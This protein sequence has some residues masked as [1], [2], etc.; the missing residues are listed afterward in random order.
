MTLAGDR[1][2]GVSRRALMQAAGWSVGLLLAPG[3][4]ADAARDFPTRLVRIVVPYPAGGGVDGLARA[5]AEKLSQ[6]WR[7]P[8]IVENKPGASTMIGSDSVV[9]SPP[10]G[11]T[12]L[13]TSDSTI[14]SNPHLFKKSPY[15]PIKDLAPVTQIID[16]HQMV[17]VHPSVAASTMQELAAL[18]KGNPGTLNYGSY[19]NGSQPHLL[20]EAFRAMTGAQIMHVPYRGIA[21]ALV[22]TIAG[23]VQMTL[24]GAATTGGYFAAGQL[25]PLAVARKE[26]LKAYPLVPTLGEAGFADIDPRPWFGLFAPVGVPPPTIARIQTDVAAILKDPAFREKYIDGMGYTGVGSTPDAFAKFI[27][28]D[29]EY[30]RRLIALA[31]VTME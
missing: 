30:K 22:A 29:F 23:E 20:F 12:L 11:Y 5:V 28:D 19:G 18:A 24:G 4:L 17:V 3:V 27:A 1:P 25:K 21:P 16:L 2:R 10:D 14:T 9:R 31:G 7:Q 26:R 6:S 13:F 15:D 8:V